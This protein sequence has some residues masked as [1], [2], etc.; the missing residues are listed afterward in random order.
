MKRFLIFFFLFPILALAGLFVFISIGV[1]AVPD[2][3]EAVW[4]VGW[5]YVVCA[6]PALLCA[7]LD[8][9]LSKTRIPAIVGTSLAGYGIAFLI[10]FVTFDNVLNRATLAFGLIGAMGAA[11]C[12]LLSGMARRPQSTANLSA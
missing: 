5:A 3:P 7:S 10:G 12:S 1:G 11:V 8:A 2:N 4:L 6:V 9:S